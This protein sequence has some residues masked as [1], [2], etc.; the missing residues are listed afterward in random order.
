MIRGVSSNVTSVLEL[1][2]KEYKNVQPGKVFENIL[3]RYTLRSVNDVTEG[4]TQES[5]MGGS[6]VIPRK[7]DKMV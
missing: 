2:F 3:F 5:P 7:V 4:I 6:W 1:S